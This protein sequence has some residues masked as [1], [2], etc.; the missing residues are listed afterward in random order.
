MA[1]LLEVALTDSQLRNY[2]TS[3]GPY[4]ELFYYIR[5]NI[6]DVRDHLVL[7]VYMQTLHM[8]GLLEA[9]SKTIDTLYVP[10]QL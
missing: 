7:M 6:E 1:G 9:T 5:N 2:W 8:A 10:F 4:D 3:S